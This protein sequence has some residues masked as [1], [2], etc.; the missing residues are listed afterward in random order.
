MSPIY[1]TEHEAHTP[2]PANGGADWLEADQ[3]GEQAWNQFYGLLLHFRSFV[4]LPL[5]WFLMGFLKIK[6]Y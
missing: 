6:P 3:W 5:E 2:T 4:S 1:L